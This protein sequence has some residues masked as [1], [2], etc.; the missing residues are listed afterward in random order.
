MIRIPAVATLFLSGA[1]GA[2]ACAPS[3]PPQEASETG[4][5]ATAYVGMTLWDGSGD[6]P[7]EDAV[8]IVR[9][10]RVEAVGPGSQVAPPTG[11]EV[12]S[13]AGLYVTP[14]L[15][16]VH[17]HVGGL[18]PAD[19]NP[20][21]GAVAELERYARFG[22][23]TVNSQGGEPVGLQTLRDTNTTT[24]EQPPSES[25]HARLF[26]AGD[27]V[28]GR[29]PE[30]ARAQVD[31]NA[32]RGVDWIKIRVDD[33]LGTAPKMLP[34]V[35]RTVIDA[36]HGHGLRLEAHVFYLDDAKDLLDAGADLIAHSV[37][38]QPVD[39][40]FA[41]ELVNRDVCYVP[42]LVREVSAF[43]YGGT[44]DY[45]ADP[46]LEADVDTAQVRFVTNP[47]RQALIAASDAA[48]AYRDALAMAQRNLDTLAEAGVTIAFGTDSGPV[49]RFQGYFEHM[50]LDL[51]VEAG[52]SP[53]SAWLAATR[54]AARCLE[55]DDL[56]T[57]EPG[58][59]A[60][61]ATFER[62]PW[63]AAQNSRTL[64]GV[65]VGG[66]AVPRPTEGTP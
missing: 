11:A 10:G 15:I 24:S 65:W 32:E 19:G 54:D 18:L 56:G 12:V 27:V 26:M 30:A 59:W 44:P 1:V 51:M 4:G 34:E 17:G 45:L 33:N 58:K 2:A 62:A 31:R 22:V 5:P 29:T 13:L 25:P 28:T 49:G 36:A 14:G 47:E 61:F 20:V 8:L 35:Y 3:G 42:T 63:E 53:E 40:A 50:E 52:M 39:D 9:D 57:L 37:R 21:P 60:D 66:N 38:D 16:N 48:A 64:Q 6:A 7:V 23:T 55:R 46:F 43:V 41:D